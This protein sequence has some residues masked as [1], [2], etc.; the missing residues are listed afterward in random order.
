MAL[1]ISND[2]LIFDGSEAITFVSVGTT[3][4]DDDGSVAESGNTSTAVASALRREVSLREVQESG[5][6]YQ[7]GD[8]WW[9]IPQVLLVASPK[10]GDRITAGSETWH[11]VEVRDS[12]LT[13]RWRTLC[14]R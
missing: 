1:D 6:R 14:R 13:S 8:V 9:T 4:V 2:Y 3:T 5:G 7:V 11:V 10:A 12:T